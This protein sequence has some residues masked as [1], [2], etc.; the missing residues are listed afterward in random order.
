MKNELDIYKEKIRYIKQFDVLIMVLGI[1]MILASYFMNNN[2]YRAFSLG[3][4]NLMIGSLQY[5]VIR[6]GNK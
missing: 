5:L 4:L 3:M 6:D 1:S 2:S